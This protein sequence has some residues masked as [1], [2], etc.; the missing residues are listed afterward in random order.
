MKTKIIFQFILLALLAAGGSGCCTYLLVDS[1]HYTT[2]DIFRPSAVYETTNLDSIALEG[3]RY[4]D[5][6]EHGLSNSNH[7]FVILPEGTLPPPN[8]QSNVTLS[9][10][11]VRTLPP[12]Y[13]Q[14]LKIKT[15]LPANFEKKA[16]LPP[17]NTSLLVK[18][19]HPRRIRYVFVP[20]TLAADVATAPIQ[21]V[22]LGVIWWEMK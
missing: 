15:Q 5:A 16:T 8:L 4:N 17:N 22:C 2:R 3:T 19:H 7:V 10:G 12:D 21:L 6:T 9:A 20:F 13:V 1:T 11:D 14:G 18:E